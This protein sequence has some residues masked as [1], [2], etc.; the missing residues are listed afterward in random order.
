M[1]FCKL[2]SIALSLFAGVFGFANSCAAEDFTFVVPVDVSHLPPDVE[3]MNVHCEVQMPGVVI[4]HSTPRII[5]IAGGAYHADVTIAFNVDAGRDPATATQ[6]IC[7]AYFIGRVPAS[8]VPAFYF[9][10][11]TSPTFPLRPG[12]PFV[13]TT[14]LQPLPR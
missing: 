1:K 11:G 5:P 6:Y 8:G 3:S 9:Q 7:S 2:L 13:L 10:Y 12:A 4:G 14:Y